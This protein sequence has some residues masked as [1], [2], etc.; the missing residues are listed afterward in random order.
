MGSSGR[1]RGRPGR[2]SPSPR[3]SSSRPISGASAR[4]CC[5]TGGPVEASRCKIR[6]QYC[7]PSEGHA[8]RQ[9]ITLRWSRVCGCR[10]FVQNI[11]IDLAGLAS[12]ETTKGRAA[13][14]PPTDFP[15]HKAT[16]HGLRFRPS[17]RRWGM[18]TA[19]AGSAPRG[20][21]A[22]IGRRRS[23]T[24]GKP[25]CRGLR[26]WIRGW[27]P[28][29]ASTASGCAWWRLETVRSYPC[30]AA[31]PRRTYPAYPRAAAVPAV[32]LSESVCDYRIIMCVCMSGR[33]YVC[34][35]GV[36]NTVVS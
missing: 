30:R 23:W 31:V 28:R 12:P 7:I 11:S 24:G 17:S 4:G 21:G 29:P 2:Q 18:C 26:R 22:R 16:T 15:G 1:C 36:G 25:A 10:L 6:S 27:R 35:Q 19:S 14:P 33:V 8:R 3:R 5:C 13:H 9:S 20:R 32:C 34:N